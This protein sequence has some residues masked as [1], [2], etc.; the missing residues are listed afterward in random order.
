MLT[1]KTTTG[2][3]LAA[4]VT[5]QQTGVDSRASNQLGIGFGSIGFT[6]AT[7]AGSAVETQLV[8]PTI[9]KRI[10]GFS[11]EPATSFGA[12]AL[13]K[14]ELDNQVFLESQNGNTLVQNGNYWYYPYN[15]AYFNNSV[16]KCTVTDT[17]AQNVFLTVYYQS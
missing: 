17:V 13:V 5:R 15:R 4:R 7:I 12:G 9:A 14:F 16:F 8:L 10:V 2:G 11:F 6:I 3:Q 1:K